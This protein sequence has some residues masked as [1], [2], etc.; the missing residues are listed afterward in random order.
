MSA[1]LGHNTTT[2]THHQR[3][4]KQHQHQ[5]DAHDQHGPSS[6]Q[7]PSI[8]RAYRGVSYEALVDK[9]RARLYCGGQHVTLGR[10][11]TPEEAARAY[12]RVAW[13][14]S[15]EHTVTNFGLT[16]AQADSD[17]VGTAPTPSRQT[18]AYLRTLANEVQAGACAK[19]DLR[20]LAG[21]RSMSEPMVT[22]AR[23]LGGSDDA[24]KSA[25]DKNVICNGRVAAGLLR[26]PCKSS[27]ISISSSSSSSSSNIGA[28]VALLCAAALRTDVSFR[29]SGN[30]GAAT[31]EHKCWGLEQQHGVVARTDCSDG[32]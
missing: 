17:A 8:D 1:N 16:A 13:Y 30:F 25:Q 31:E 18:Q 10:F 14:V 3:E 11:A 32:G 7:P 23:G 29:A 28:A 21:R 26:N 19:S 6:P 5:P 9:W 15:K 4:Q 2:A 20:K 22:E 12:D 24:R 27:S